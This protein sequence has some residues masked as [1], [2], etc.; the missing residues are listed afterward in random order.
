[1]RYWD[2]VRTAF[3]VARQGTVSG[4]ANVLG[5]HHTTVI[6]HIDA[7]EAHL[8]QKLF[9]RHARGYTQTEAGKELLRVAQ[10]TDDQFKQLEARLRNKEGDLSGEVVVTSLQELS[11]MVTPLLAQFQSKNPAIKINYSTGERLF[12]LEYGEA[13]LA[14]RA[15]EAPKD[16]D[17]VVQP[18]VNFSVGLFASPDYIAVKGILRGS[19]DLMSHQFVLHGDEGLR[20]PHYAF[21]RSHLNA[22][23]IAFQSTD[24]SV[25]AQAINAGIGIGYLPTALGQRMGLQQVGTEL[26][27]WTFPLWLVTH[28][29]LHRSPKVQALLEHFKAARRETNYQQ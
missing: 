14:I 17:N 15:G 12:R 13:H 18:F 25:L 21:L 9:Q 19:E 16:P 22:E 23:N 3:H 27:D 26:Q 6:R 8:G 2:E 24:T 1:M 10:A 28:V 5:L 4:A 7:L 20:A 29:D 11:F